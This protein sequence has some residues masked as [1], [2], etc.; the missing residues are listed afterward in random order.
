[1]VLDAHAV[2]SSASKAVS[3]LLMSALNLYALVVQ[4]SDMLMAEHV[5]FMLITKKHTK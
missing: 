3:K 5:S 2:L 1:M 4:R